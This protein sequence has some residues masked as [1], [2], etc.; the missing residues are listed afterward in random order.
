MPETPY[1]NQVTRVNG[2]SNQITGSV[3]H[4]LFVRWWF[5][6]LAKSWRFGMIMFAWCSLV[7]ISSHFLEIVLFDWVGFYKLHV[8]NWAVDIHSFF[9]SLMFGSKYFVECLLCSCHYSGAQGKLPA[10][11]ALGVC[12]P[13][14]NLLY[15]NIIPTAVRICTARSN[16][17]CQRRKTSVLNFQSLDMAFAM[18]EGFTLGS[19][20]FLW[21]QEGHTPARNR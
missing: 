6:H 19:S 14:N 1:K 13:P 3:E 7:T 17:I 18:L 5:M 2:T 11:E 21:S 9:H 15:P 20:S 4:N 16:Q 8:A 10:L 12:G